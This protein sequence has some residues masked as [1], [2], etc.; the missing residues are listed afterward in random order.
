MIRNGKTLRMSVG[1]VLVGDVVLVTT[2]QT[3]EFDG[4]VLESRRMHIDDCYYS[5][6]VAG[7]QRFM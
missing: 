2:G 3:L 1:E 4:V 5:C 6:Y 7:S